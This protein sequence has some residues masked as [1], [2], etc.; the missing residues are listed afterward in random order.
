MFQT[1]TPASIPF[2]ASD[3]ER[4]I[5]WLNYNGINSVRESTTLSAEQYQEQISVSAKSHIQ[6][7]QLTMII[8]ITT[9]VVVFLV[10][11][12][13]LSMIMDRQYQM[14]KFFVGMDKI[15]V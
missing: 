15:R 3:I 7:A 4:T 13:M 2:A 14:I 1:L 11:T 12:P 6:N 10:V 5:M 9:I 8:S